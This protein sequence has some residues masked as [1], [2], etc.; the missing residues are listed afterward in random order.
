MERQIC[1]CVRGRERERRKEKMR[2]RKE[3]SKGRR[4]SP[5]GAL[6]DNRRRTN[7]T[8]YQADIPGIRTIDARPN[9]RKRDKYGTHNEERRSGRSRRRQGCRRIRDLVWLS[10]LYSIPFLSVYVRE[11]PASNIGCIAVVCGAT[12]VA[13]AAV[14]ALRDRCVGPL[15]LTLTLRE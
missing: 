12:A 3:I 2:A 6:E 4:G 11:L 14:A 7:A 1:E 13:V 10:S 5:P 8:V 9:W 15:T